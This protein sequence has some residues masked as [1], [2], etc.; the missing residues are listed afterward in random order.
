MVSAVVTMATRT[1]SVESS[2]EMSSG[3]V[4]SPDEDDGRFTFINFDM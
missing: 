4:T 1:P 2:S 3:D